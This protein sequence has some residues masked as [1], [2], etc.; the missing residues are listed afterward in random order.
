M[1]LKDE[2]TKKPK[3]LMEFLHS[4]HLESV[5]VKAEIGA[6]FIQILERFTPEDLSTNLHEMLVDSVATSQDSTVVQKTQITTLVIDA[7]LQSNLLVNQA[8]N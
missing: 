8:L 5:Q 2:Q 1:Q 6:M 7:F 4:E 3:T